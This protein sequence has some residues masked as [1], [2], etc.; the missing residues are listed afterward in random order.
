MAIIKFNEDVKD[1]L[2]TKGNTYVF[3]DVE[4]KWE[5]TTVGELALS[6]RKLTAYPINAAG[7]LGNAY[8]A[9][10]VQQRQ[11]LEDNLALHVRE[12]VKK[13]DGTVDVNWRA[14]SG[15]YSIVGVTKDAA[16]KQI[17]FNELQY[18]ILQPESNETN[19]PMLNNYIKEVIVSAG[20][21]IFVLSRA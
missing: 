13:D 18:L 3:E 15:K 21:V 4:N 2:L 1:L 6:L 14:L 7:H 10:V 11:W 9:D 17:P 5:I 8:T 20:K 19:F 12:M 16:E